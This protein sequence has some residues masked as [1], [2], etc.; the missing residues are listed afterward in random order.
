MSTLGLGAP[1]TALD[2]ATGKTLKVYEGTEYA[3][4]IL[5][6]DKTIYVVAGNSEV[7]R[8]GEG[9][10]RRGEPEPTDFRYITALDTETGQPLWKREFDKEDFLLPLTL[11]VGDDSVV[12]QSTVGVTCLNA[13]SGERRWQAARPTPQRRM[14]FSAPTIV[15]ADGVVLS[16]DRDVS[17]KEPPASGSIEWGVNGWNEPGFSRKGKASLCAYRLDDGEQLWSVACSEGYNSPVDVFV[18]DGT[19]WVGSDYKRY[20][21]KTGMAL[22]PLTWKVGNVAMAHHRCYRNKAS[23]NFIFTGRAGVEVVDLE[24]GLGWQ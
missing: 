7:H 14:G 13:A 24:S 8:S 20:E 5:V 18:I 9:L 11:A 4:E 2:A 23:E 16:A 22:E 17:Q 19:V 10:F 21:L 12:Y 3:E 1:V 6:K 15:L